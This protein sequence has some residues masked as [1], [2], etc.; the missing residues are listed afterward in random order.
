MSSPSLVNT[1]N[2]PERE[3]RSRRA[4]S[5]DA[6][7]VA[8]VGLLIAWPLA[9]GWGELGKARYIEPIALGLVY[10]LFA[11]VLLGSH[12]WHGDTLETLG[13]GSPRRFL[14]HL[15]ESRGAARWGIILVFL[16][17]FG[18]IIFFCL[19][20][21]PDAAKFFRLPKSYR[22]IPDASWK[23][24]AIAVASAIVAGLL[25]TCTI[26]YDNFLP[27][28][29]LALTLAVVLLAYA[30]AIAYSYQGEKTFARIKWPEH[31]LDAGAHMFWGLIQQFL[32]TG[33]FATRLRKAFGPS[34]STTNVLA[35]SKRLL[36]VVLGAVAA[37]VVIG[38]V[39]YYALR[40]VYGHR[41]PESFLIG[42]IGF[43]APAGAIWAY[44]FSRDKKR[45]LVATL[46]GSLFAVI[47]VDSYGL[48]LSTGILGTIFAYVAMEDR[49]RNLAA[50]G[51]VHGLL[52]ATLVKL[53]SDK[54]MLK[55]S[56]SVG[57]WSVEDPKRT[58]LILPLVAV[59]IYA[60]I[61]WWA[62]RNLD[63]AKPSVP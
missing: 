15:R 34:A 3:L 29:G 42:C 22:V 61:A 52:G 6:L 2:E 59:A 62:S 51:F 33:Y 45:L 47:H 43:A 50:F 48:V 46:S 24:A 7:G 19:A 1:A 11:W 56:L 21:W 12:R 27:S 13:L 40:T 8:C 25:A 4:N 9:F 28:F 23:W 35:G 17:I 41:I 55:I 20:D 44:F 30:I 14:Q 57:P 16:T 63:D 58:V 18:G 37:A 38:P 60:F 31:A 5:L 32:F 39:A 36:T 10:L 26:R 54:K 53:F 49:F